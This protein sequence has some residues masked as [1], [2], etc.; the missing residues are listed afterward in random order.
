MS[1]TRT[2]RIEGSG[3]Q[4][5][6]V[7]PVGPEGPAGATGTPGSMTGP[8]VATADAIVL[9]NG[10]TGAVVK[11]STVTLSSLATAAAMTAALALKEDKVA[12]KGLSAN[13]FTTV[14]KNKLDAL[15]TA[16]YKGS[17][18]SL[19]AL[20]AAHPAGAAGDWAHVEVAA[21]VLKLYHWDSVNA[22]WQI[23]VDLSGKVDKVTGYGLS[24]NDFSDAYLSM[25]STAVQTTTF[26]A[27]FDALEVSIAEFAAHLLLANAYRAITA[28][29]V[30][31]PLT[32]FTVNCT[33][34]SFAVT[35]PTAIGITGQEFRIKNSGTGVTT[36]NTTAGQTIDGQVSG[37]ISL[38]QYS[39]LQ[40][41]SDGA[42]WIIL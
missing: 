41:L 1:T 31:N 17:H 37:A 30:I 3:N 9:F 25:L 2:I 28:A 13:D 24:K 11:D 38:P 42:N 27:A 39:A 7:R 12:G 4:R 22:S 32:D 29:G 40:V 8:G 15:G 20:Q 21:A 36:I 6:I 5:T 19:A 35:L 34:N 23:G 16:T 33:A 18:V 10:T 26:E 14:L